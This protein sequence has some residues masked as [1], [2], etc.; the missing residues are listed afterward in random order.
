MTTKT[1]VNIK[2]REAI[3]GAEISRKT[4]R[5]RRNV[6][7]PHHHQ[8]APMVAAEVAVDRHAL[9]APNTIRHKEAMTLA[10]D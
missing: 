1:Q 2:H 5:A 3:V 7:R 10:H 4:L 9:E 8:A 6:S